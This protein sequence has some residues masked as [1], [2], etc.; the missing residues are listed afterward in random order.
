MKERQETHPRNQNL[1]LNPHILDVKTHAVMA[2]IRRPTP[3]TPRPRVQP[4]ASV[5]NSL[6]NH[7]VRRNKSIV[8]RPVF[9]PAV[10][11]KP[12]RA[13]KIKPDG[14]GVRS[15]PPHG[16]GLVAG[17]GGG[18]HVPPFYGG[19]VYEGGVRAVKGPAAV[20][21]DEATVAIYRMGWDDFCCG[22]EV[23]GRGWT[24]RYV[25]GNEGE[26]EGDEGE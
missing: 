1:P 14:G 18:V 22:G 15:H 20:R 8:A 19:G 7:L 9:K 2:H 10:E 3:P 6:D 12:V 17:H 23:E 11:N 25:C 21:V 4:T 16:D 5:P 24:E 26:D 13:G